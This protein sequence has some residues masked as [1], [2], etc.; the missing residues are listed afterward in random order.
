MLI[1]EDIWI[2]QNSDFS[3]SIYSWNTCLFEKLVYNFWLNEVYNLI[4]E[5]MKNWEIKRWID[6]KDFLNN[7]QKIKNELEK[8]NKNLKDLNWNIELKDNN[9]IKNNFLT[10]KEDLYITIS[11][12]SYI[13]NFMTWDEYEAVIR[14]DISLNSILIWWV[15]ENFNDLLKKYKWEDNWKS[16]IIFLPIIDIK[17]VFSKIPRFLISSQHFWVSVYEEREFIFDNDALIKK[18]T[19]DYNWIENNYNWVDVDEWLF[20]EKEKW[21]WLRYT[22]DCAPIL[23][24]TIIHKDEVEKRGT[25]INISLKK[26]FEKEF[27][28]NK[29][30]NKLNKI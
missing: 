7:K 11:L 20:I 13:K 17:E 1:K 21:E 3:Y 22:F 26:L 19:D 18:F 14:K 12:Y 24:T 25:K 9:V 30:I 6:I 15:E 16:L 4:D 10:K 29:K 23:S 8:D 5:W 28:I 27:Y 2:K